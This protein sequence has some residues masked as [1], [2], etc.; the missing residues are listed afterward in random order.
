MCGRGR[1]EWPPRI[2]EVSVLLGE[3]Q[4]VEFKDYR[5]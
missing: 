3:C 2:V 1:G 5:P 4:H